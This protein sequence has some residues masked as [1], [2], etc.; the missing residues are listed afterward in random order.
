MTSHRS[1]FTCHPGGTLPVLITGARGRLARL[2]AKGLTG[3]GEQRLFSREPG[4]GI[5]AL[6]DLFRPGGLATGGVLLHLAWSSLPATAE[7]RPEWHAEQ[8]LG[9]LRRLLDAVEAVPAGARPHFVFFSTGGAVYGNAP[10]RPSREDDVCRPVGHYGRTKLA[11]EGDIRTWS[12]RTG[13]SHTI[14][15]IANPYGFA[16]PQ[17]RPQGI[18]PHAIRAAVAGTPLTL[19]GDGTARKDFIHCRDFLEALERVI[20]H[21]PQGTFNLGTGESH[22]LLEVIDEVERQTGRTIARSHVAA[23]PWDVHDSR[24]SNAKLRAATGWAPKVS[25]AEGIRLSLA[26]SEGGRGG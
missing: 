2:V 4:A 21:R 5:E 14:L 26:A 24:L 23:T 1:L 20:E 9:L 25:L 22:T 10:G 6:E 8:D 18:I 13:A 12:A 17:E 19:W 16:V 11:A 7:Q 3:Q 15:R